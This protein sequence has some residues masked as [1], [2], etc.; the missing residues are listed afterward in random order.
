MTLLTQLK[1]KELTWNFSTFL[2]MASGG[3]LLNLVLAIL[4]GPTG[5][6]VFN[7][8][9]AFFL[10]F[11]QIST[12]GCQWAVLHLAAKNREDE[13]FVASTLIAS[14]GVTLACSLL[15]AVLIFF[16]APLVGALFD[17]EPIEKGYQ[18]IAPFIVFFGVNKLLINASNSLGRYRL[19]SIARASRFIL[20]A[21]VTMAFYFSG[22]PI[23]ALP[24]IFCFTEVLLCL[25]LSS[26]YAGLLL[27]G[28]R[29]GGIVN[30]TKQIVP[31]GLKSLTG[32]AVAEFNTR[33]DIIILGIFLDDDLVG[34][35]SIAA[36]FA[37][38]LIELGNIVRFIVNPQAP[39]LFA[40]EGVAGLEP[41]YRKWRN[42]TMLIVT[43]V[44]IVSS[45]IY[46]FVIELV[47]RDPEFIKGWASYSILAAGIAMASGYK[48]LDMSFNQLGFPA[49]QTRY[50]LKIFFANVVANFL[51]IPF[52]GLTGAAIGT[53]ISFLCGVYWFKRTIHR[54]I[55]LKI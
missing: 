53:V 48:A 4:Y 55:G 34:I 9:F 16:S 54:L 11:G 13:G 7:Q 30:R 44:A 37:E 2:V 46:P 39:K 29:T 45:L 3:L 8:V 32:G 43:S 42:T 25:L 27:K 21:I 52:I 24:L 28:I 19:F 49:E 31:F 33:T 47:I 5:V 10:V 36:L 23:W 1:N 20:L 14:I 35:Y 15:I 6:G 22:G 50:R 26:I 38:G 41:F 12:L 51:L 18:A 17:S 40:E